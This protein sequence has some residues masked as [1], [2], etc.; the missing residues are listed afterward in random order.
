MCVKVLL[1][2]CLDLVRSLYT[3]KELSV[4]EIRTDRIEREAVT[5]IQFVS[6]QMP[7][8]LGLSGKSKALN[9]VANIQYLRPSKQVYVY[10]LRTFVL[11]R[12]VTVPASRRQH[13]GSHD[14]KSA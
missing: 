10:H 3:Q 14:L 9:T 1:I 13:A 6:I 8:G 7:G 12:W 5:P 11:H 2:R 4:I